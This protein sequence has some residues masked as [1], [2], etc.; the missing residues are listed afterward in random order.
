[1][2]TVK[3]SGLARGDSVK[4]WTSSNKSIATV[5]KNGKITATAKEGKAT[6]TVTL[7]SGKTAKVAVTVKLIR[8]TKLNATILY[9]S[10]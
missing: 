1:M 9:S 3:A 7:A 5:D 4:K 2:L 8:T 10:I 6:I